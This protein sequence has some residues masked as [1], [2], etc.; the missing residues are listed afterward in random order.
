MN[1][2]KKARQLLTEGGYTCVLCKGDIVY[3]STHRGVRPLMDLL[4]TD[5]SGFSA[6]DKVVGKATALLYC[7]LNIKELHTCII[8]DAAAEVLQTHNIPVQWDFRVPFIKNREGTGRCPM[9]TATE[10]IS[11]PADAPEAIR[12]KLKELQG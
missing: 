10:G 11:N 4:D 5:V 6:A 1:D 9:E 3:T 8:S 2:L 7:L 12:K